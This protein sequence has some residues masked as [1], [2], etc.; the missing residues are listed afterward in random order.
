MM[1]KE[2]SQASRAKMSRSAKQAWPTERREEQAA[3]MRNRKWSP[4][5]HKKF[6]ATMKA[7]RAAGIPGNRSE[8]VPAN[9]TPAQRDAL[10]KAKRG[11]KSK[12][13]TLA[14]V[15][16][17]GAPP[18]L[19]N[20]KLGVRRGYKQKP[21]HVARILAAKKEKAAARTMQGLVAH[22]NGNGAIVAANEITTEVKV[23]SEIAFSFGNI[24]LI[25]RAVA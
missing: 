17:A 14:L 11:H 4:A 5:T 10:A 16:A 22:H 9:F 20:G 21:E 13:A 2:F 12:A 19:G 24:R 18:E 15:A 23:G 25:V 7:K 3:R 6:A 1:P 8:P